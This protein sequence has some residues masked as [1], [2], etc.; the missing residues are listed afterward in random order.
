MVFYGCISADIEEKLRAVKMGRTGANLAV[1]VAEE[2]E[3]W[4]VREAHV[5]V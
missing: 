1:Q 5:A 2:E 4:G 3:N